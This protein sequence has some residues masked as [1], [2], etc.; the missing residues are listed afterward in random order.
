MLTQIFRQFTDEKMVPMPSGTI[1]FRGGEADVN[2]AKE[3]RRANIFLSTN[4]RT[5]R[6][7]S[8]FWQVHRYSY[9]YRAELIRDVSLV[10]VRS[11]KC[12]VQQSLD[13]LRLSYTT[14]LTWQRDELLHVARAALPKIVMDGIYFQDEAGLTEVILDN[15]GGLIRIMDQIVFP[16][17]ADSEYAPDINRVCNSP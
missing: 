11:M 14:F 9:I 16:R 17:G 12:C 13:H 6:N 5:C 3:P 7:Y 2:D 1:F 15:S 8:N 10:N 4:N